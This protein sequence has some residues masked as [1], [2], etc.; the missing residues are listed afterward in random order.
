MTSLPAQRGSLVKTLWLSLSLSL[1]DRPAQQ[2]QQRKE[3]TT[4]SVGTATQPRVPS[5]AAASQDI[6]RAVK[7]GRRPIQ[8]PGRERKRQ[9]CLGWRVEVE[10]TVIHNGFLVELEKSKNHHPFR[11][12]LLSLLSLSS[13]SFSSC[14]SSSHSHSDRSGSDTVNTHIHSQSTSLPHRPPSPPPRRFFIG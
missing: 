11:S 3:D 14:S 6:R 4:Y 2:P 7:A 1:D 5:R 8:C 9:H 13:P 12:P 10:T